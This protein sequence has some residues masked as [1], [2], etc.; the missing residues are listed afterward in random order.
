MATLVAH[1]S[2]S[3]LL[4]EVTEQG[5]AF[6][7]RAVHQP[8][9]D[10]LAAE[11]GSGPFEPAAPVIGQV[12]QQV[13]CFQI[14]VDQLPMRY[15]VLAGLCDELVG[16]VNRHGV[17]DWIPNEVAV[18]RYQ[19]ESLGITP[20]RDQ[21]RFAALVAVV[22]VAG[23]APFTLCRNRAGDPIWTWQADAGSL[24]L[25]RGPGLAGDP[26]GRPMHAVGTPTG[27]TARTS[28]GIRMD[29]GPT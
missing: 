11:L 9:C 8:C 17:P 14:S 26:D 27:A 15:P 24:V 7:A 5:V 13:E 6:A 1:L 2:W 10:Q 20:H 16:Q 21:R 23:S 25:L 19:S 12:R 3:K 22:T 29:T 18:Q 4:R 28:I